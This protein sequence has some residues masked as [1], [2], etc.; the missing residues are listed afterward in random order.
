MV[1]DVYILIGTYVNFDV[2]YD[3]AYRDLKSMN[4]QAQAL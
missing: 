1:K 4:A 2:N 3:H